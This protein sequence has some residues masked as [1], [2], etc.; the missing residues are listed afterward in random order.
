MERRLGQSTFVCSGRCVP[1]SLPL[2]HSPF[3]LPP[4]PPPVGRLP[5]QRVIYEIVMRLDSIR[6]VSWVRAMNAY[7]MIYYPP[8]CVD[9]PIDSLLF[10]VFARVYGR[11]N[12]TRRKIRSVHVRRKL[13]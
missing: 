9:R 12:F 7:C 10:R 13:N 3:S 4:F 6:G 11:I 2:P 5:F 1:L 8:G